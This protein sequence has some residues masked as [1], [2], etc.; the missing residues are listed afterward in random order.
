[1]TALSDAEQAVAEARGRVI[2]HLTNAGLSTPRATANADAL[3]AAVRHHDAET[4]LEDSKSPL[5]Q[6]GGKFH[7]G[8]HHAADL[9]RTAT[10]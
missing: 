6:Q 10:A 7:S 8:M 2:V 9:I 5:V 3:I 4:I 1:V